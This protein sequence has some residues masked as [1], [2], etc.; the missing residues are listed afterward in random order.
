MQEQTDL[1]PSESL[2]HF[3]CVVIYFNELLILSHSPK[4]ATRRQN[5][6]LKSLHD[7]DLKAEANQEVAQ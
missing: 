6:Q 4:R 7:A 5:E 2:R 3:T 1:R